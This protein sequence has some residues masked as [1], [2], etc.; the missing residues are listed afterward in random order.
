MKLLEAELTP[1]FT[2]GVF[3]GY[4]EPDLPAPSD[5]IFTESQQF[6]EAYAGRLNVMKR[7]VA[8]L[9]ITNENEV[10]SIDDD[11]SNGKGNIS[12]YFDGST[13]AEG[14]FLWRLTAADTVCGD[15]TDCTVLTSQNE[16]AIEYRQFDSQ[17]RVRRKWSDETTIDTNLAFRG[18]LLL[19]RS[20][21]VPKYLNKHPR[22]AP[23]KKKKKTAKAKPEQPIFTDDLERKTGQHKWQGSESELAE[24]TL[25]ALEQTDRF[26]VQHQETAKGATRVLERFNEADWRRYDRIKKRFVRRLTAKD[27]KATEKTVTLM[28]GWLEAAHRSQDAHAVVVRAGEKL[29]HYLLDAKVSLPAGYIRA[30]VDRHLVL[31]TI[32]SNGVV[33]FNTWHDIEDPDVRPAQPTDYEILLRSWH[34]EQ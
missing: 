22:H 2:G 11:A 29:A 5:D 30:K 1:P 26:R 33:V 10:Y 14:I 19:M 13:A 24:L 9:V 16:R 12:L 18:I 28:E 4:K 23:T 15:R 8:Q 34:K 25:D 20:P 21:F 17:G 27:K 31:A 32:T 6:L 7:L 3:L